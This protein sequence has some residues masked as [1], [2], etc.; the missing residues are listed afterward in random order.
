MFYFLKSK[1]QL[2]EVLIKVLLNVQMRHALLQ[3]SFQALICILDLSHRLLPPLRPLAFFP[4]HLFPP[5]FDPLNPPPFLFPPT[6]ILPFLPILKSFF[7]RFLSRTF[8]L[9][10]SSVLEPLPPR[11]MRECGPLRPLYLWPGPSFMT[12][13]KSLSPMSSPFSRIRFLSW[14]I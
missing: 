8:S 3:R 4:G 14:L 9:T 1:L 10:L 6:F 2:I 5:F 13:S 12:L 11:V 7:F